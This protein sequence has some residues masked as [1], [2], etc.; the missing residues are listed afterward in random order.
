MVFNVEFGI[1]PNGDYSVIEVNGR[2]SATM[3][4]N[5]FIDN[6]PFEILFKDNEFKALKKSIKYRIFSSVSEV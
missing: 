4:Q 2:T 5:T 6:D 3:F 1:E